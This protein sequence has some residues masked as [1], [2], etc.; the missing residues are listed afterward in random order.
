MKSTG[1]LLRAL[2]VLVSLLV[3]AELLY[4][5]GANLFLSCGGLSKLF[6]STNT[7]DAKFRSAWTIWPGHVHIRGLRVVFQDKNLQW[8]LDVERAQL[9]LRLTELT[10][11]AFHAESVS[12]DG[13]VFRFRHR[14][15]PWSRNDPSV[16]ALAPISEFP[17]TAV[18]EAGAPEAPLTDE[19]YDLWTVHLEN[20]DVGVSEVWVQQFRYVGSGRARGAFRLRPARTVWV[21]PASLTLESGRLTAGHYRLSP[22]LAG[23]VECV[24]HP[25][26]VRKPDG[27]EVLRFISAR[28]DLRAPGFSPAAIELFLPQENTSAIAEGGDLVVNARMDR[29]TILS[30][31]ELVLRQRGLVVEHP[32]GKLEFERA[33]L[34]AHADGDGHGEARWELGNGKLTLRTSPAAPVRVDDV[35]ASVVSSSLDAAR[36]WTVLEAELQELRGFAPDVRWFNGF[37]AQTDWV[38]SRGEAGISARGRYEGGELE[39]NVQAALRDVRAQ[40]S[41]SKLVVD[42]RATLT[43]SKARVSELRGLVTGDLIGGHVALERGATMF[44]ANGVRVEAR[45]QAGDGTARAQL[46]A[47]VDS[48]SARAGGFSLSGRTT[49]VGDIQRWDLRDGTANGRVTAELEDV[50]LRS[51]DSGLTAR[52]KHASLRLRSERP[53]PSR[54]D[55]NGASS[56]LTVNAALGQV[57]FATGAADERFTGRADELLLRARVAARANGDIDALL[58]SSAPALEAA[59]GRESFK[60]SPELD[61]EIA[62]LNRARE[63]GRIRADLVVRAFSAND[64]ANDEHCPWSSVELGRLRADAVLGENE[65]AKL[66]V[67]GEL[68]AM[69]VSYTHLT[70]PT[71]RIV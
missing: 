40:S 22:A 35:K 64:T 45:A 71:K 21:G 55:R 44:E 36:D 60:G 48:L 1:R 57:T 41:D 20:V 49:L 19:K 31:S 24:V 34:V 3:A 14:V 4:L 30:P 68:S 37:L 53:E 58:H 47:R 67:S 33:A 32:R 56:L 28:V 25:F 50:S 54:H 59:Y 27:R 23:R 52:A 9:V 15:D 12:G 51:L 63:R 5:I 39:G 61:V 42:G 6:A 70:L 38:S 13:A 29:G 65:S 10:S 62:G 2:G 18:F 17:G 11:R 26:D 46:T 66:S 8:S 7:I 69:T 16:R 43:W